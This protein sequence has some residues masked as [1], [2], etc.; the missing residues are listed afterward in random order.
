MTSRTSNAFRTL[1]ALTGSLALTAAGPSFSADATTSVSGDST[2]SDCGAA[3]KADYSIKLTGSLT[4]CW[5]TFISQFNC[6]E[7]DG[8]ALYTELGREEFEG[9]LDGEAVS[10]NTVYT[11]SGLFPSGSCPEP[12]AEQEITGGCL[13]YVSGVGLV[14]VIRFH[15]VMAGE[16][17]PHYF[18]EGTL[19]HG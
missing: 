6:Q 4:G 15:D 5:A 2:P 10:F 9:K 3:K 18:Y 12:A 1:V 16:G 14:G 7:K 13:H 17:A 8:F 11:F 19:T